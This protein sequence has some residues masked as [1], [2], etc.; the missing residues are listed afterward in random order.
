MSAGRKEATPVPTINQTRTLLYT[1]ARLLGDVQAVK[2]GRIG[3]R[4]LRRAAGKI[5]GR[6]L[7]RLFR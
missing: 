3:R 6:A 7:G 1:I 5:T 4:I 2:S